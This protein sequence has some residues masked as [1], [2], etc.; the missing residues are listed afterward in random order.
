MDPDMLSR[1]ILAWTSGAQPWP[2]TDD[3][4][5]TELFGHDEGRA[6]LREV[7]QLQDEFFASDAYSRARSE[8]EL[9]ELAAADFTARHPEISAEAV[10]RFATAYAYAWR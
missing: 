4:R 3:T 10:E 9:G 1:A 5:V 6:V 2:T 8:A 7:R